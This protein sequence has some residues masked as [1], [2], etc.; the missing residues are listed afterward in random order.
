MTK[1]EVITSDI[2]KKIQNGTFSANTRLPTEPELGEQY[3]VS[4]ITVKKAID[5]LVAEGLCYKEE[6]CW[7]LCQ[8]ISRGGWRAF[9]SS[10]RIV[11]HIR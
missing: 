4:R 5:K 11:S 8:R 7:N 2:R 6:R 3:N 1:Y 9:S 10:Q